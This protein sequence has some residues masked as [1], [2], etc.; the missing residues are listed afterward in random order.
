MAVYIGAVAEHAEEVQDRE[1]RLRIKGVLGPWA[2]RMYGDVPSSDCNGPQII[3]NEYLPNSTGRPHYHSVDQFQLVIA[4]SGLLG[5]HPL[6]PGSLHY[7]NAYTPYGPLSAGPE[8][9]T[10]LTLRAKVD[11]GQRAMPQ[12]A[13]LRKQAT[14]P[15]RARPRAYFFELNLDRGEFGTVAGPY[16][17]GL[18]VCRQFVQGGEPLDFVAPSDCGGW[19]LTVLSGAVAK[20]QE[21][22]AAPAGVFCG[23]RRACEHFMRGSPW[24]RRSCAEV[25]GAAG[26]SS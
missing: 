1:K 26:G 18:E 8:G 17:D 5:K 13:A 12:D 14:P 9:L 6:Q 24:R 25:S 4:G 3:F 11:A 10:V 23:S 16:D 22:Y 2:G 20:G 21:E 7:A 15:D 19:I